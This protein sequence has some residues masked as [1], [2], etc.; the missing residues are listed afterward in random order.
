MAHTIIQEYQFWRKEDI[1]YN[2]YIDAS[3]ALCCKSLVPKTWIPLDKKINQSAWTEKAF[4]AK[5]NFWQLDDKNLLIY[6]LARCIF[7]KE[8]FKDAYII[9]I[10]KRLNLFNDIYVREAM[11]LVFFKFTPKL[12][13]LIKNKNY[14]SIINE[15][16]SFKEY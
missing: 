11:E 9:E 5:N 14:A 6:L 13:N 12:V 8:I 3:F 16:I 7:D 1:E 4:D 15:Y 10:E 2:L